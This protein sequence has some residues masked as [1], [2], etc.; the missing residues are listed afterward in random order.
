MLSSGHNMALALM[1]T[2]TEDQDS[3][4]SSVHEVDD[5]QGLPPFEELLTVNSS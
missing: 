2:S 3:R 1:V 5:P 4:N